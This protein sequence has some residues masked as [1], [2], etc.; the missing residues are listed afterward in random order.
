[1]NILFI[2]DIVGAP[3]RK[4]VLNHLKQLKETYQIDLTIANGENSAHGKGI[5]SKIYQQFITAGIDVITLGN[6]AF[7]KSEIMPYLNG[8]P[9]LVRPKNMLPLKGGQSVLT[10]A[11]ASLNVAVIN[12]YGEV[13]MDHV[14][15]SWKDAMDDILSQVKADVYFVDFHGEATSEKQTFFYLYQDRISAVVGTHT[16]V[17]TAD[18][19]VDQ[20][21]AY[22]SDVGMCG[23]IRSVLG[24]DV[25]EVINRT[26]FQEKTHY[27]VAEG[28]AM[29]NA[30]VI[31]IDEDSKRAR[32]IQ[33][34]CINE[35]VPS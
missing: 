28:A 1:M 19:K 25:D 31:T 23:A 9:R 15:G 11:A 35:S 14:G 22:I 20:G 24:R 26:I 10:I 12:L 29:L 18:E 8:L 34:L 32:A 17:Q 27:T 6:H 13:F 2:G 33:R 5:T 21:C 7:S 4:M 3:G 30:V 16:H